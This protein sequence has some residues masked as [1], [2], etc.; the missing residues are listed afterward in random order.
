M[1]AQ[2]SVLQASKAATLGERDGRIVLS[3]MTVPP[4]QQI[5]LDVPYGYEARHVQV[6]VD[7]EL[8]TPTLASY[9]DLE[10]LE[11]LAS[12]LAWARSEDE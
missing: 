6:T 10:L 3:R 2:V 7:P 12:R 9:T 8:S 5:S 4:G 11:E 1:S